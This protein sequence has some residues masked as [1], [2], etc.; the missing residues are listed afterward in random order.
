MLPRCVAAC[1][2]FAIFAVAASAVPGD[3]RVAT[4]HGDAKGAFVFTLDD[5]DWS[6]YPLAGYPCISSAEILHSHGLVGTYGLIAAGVDTD[7]EIA[8]VT[9]LADMGHEIASHGLWH[10]NL[11]EVVDTPTMYRE[12]IRSKNRL[13]SLLDGHGKCESYLYPNCY[14]NATNI[15]YGLNVAG[16]TALRHTCGN[17]NPSFPDYPANHFMTIGTTALGTTVSEARGFIDNLA[18]NGGH[19]VTLT[20]TW[21]TMCESGMA[22]SICVYLG[23]KV[24]EG[25]I[26]NPTFIG[27]TKYGQERDA[28]ILTPDPSPRSYDLELTLADSLE[29]TVFNAPL[30][31]I[32]EV[33]AEWDSAGVYQNDELVGVFVA[34]GGAVVY[35]AI[36]DGGIIGLTRN[37][38]TVGLRNATTRTDI[39][40][41]QSGTARLLGLDGRMIS[42]TGMPHT[43]GVAACCDGMRHSVRLRMGGTSLR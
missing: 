7:A 5:Y 19:R 35:D 8:G 9:T 1:W 10:T 26:W 17:G 21:R 3:T 32:T 4:W 39:G 2:A 16:Y 11:V 43:L 31:L 30:T 27:L 37:G 22:D 18:A 33:P 34:H 20:H 23:T 42:R 41:T 36:P 6:H 40:A 29:D 28:A 38:A 13:D 24:A 15:D 12:M 14:G 25:A